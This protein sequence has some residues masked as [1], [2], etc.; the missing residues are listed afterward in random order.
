MKVLHFHI[1][2]LLAG[3]IEKA[4][5]KL[6]CGLDPARY[7]IRLSVT[8]SL[9]ELETLKKEIPSYVSVHY[10]LT[11]QLSA[12]KK[13]KVTNTISLPGR[14]YEELVLPFLKK[15]MHVV[16]L[17]EL[18]SDSDVIIDF[19]MTLT[20]YTYLLRNNKKVA[21]CHTSLGNYWDGNTRKLNKLANR[22][23]NYDKVVV[24]CEEMKLT[25]TELFPALKSSMQHIYNALDNDRIQTMATESLGAYDYLLQDGYFVSVGRLAE[26]QKD[27]TMLIKG[28]AACVKKY[29]IKE[30]LAIVGE[31]YSRLA[32]E[33]LAID[34]GV[35]E[36]VA[37]PGYQANP[38]KWMRN[39]ELF[40]FCSKYE[41]VPAVLAEALALSCPI[42]ATATPTGVQELLMYGKCGMLVKPGDVAGFGDAIYTLLKD[43]AQQETYRGNTKEILGRF[44]MK[45][46]V[47]EFEEMVEA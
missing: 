24:P 33:E 45:T 40:L 37:F 13:K 4:L 26:N 17:K 28:F 18:V 1:S 23:K 36:L 42:V 34:E 21:Y 3:S 20:P 9:G 14:L 46:M 16:K 19:D 29:G 15:S 43:K 6:L 2:S 44:E 12:T 35:G 10:I 27:F 47:R 39:S 31:G 30:H 41:G 38:Y 32:L 8:H 11:E 25:A 7:T 22:L 5:I